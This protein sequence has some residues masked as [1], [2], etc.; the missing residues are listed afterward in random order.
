MNK[1]KLVTTSIPYV[2]DKFPEYY[3]ICRKIKIYLMR[4]KLD[5]EINSEQYLTLAG[6][7]RRINKNHQNYINIKN[8]FIKNNHVA[9]WNDVCKFS[10][11]YTRYIQG[12][13]LDFD[14]RSK[15]YLNWVFGL[16]CDVSGDM[17]MFLVPNSKACAEIYGEGPDAES[18]NNNE[19]E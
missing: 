14:Y 7:I 12:S 18:E 3:E 17:C 10:K 5:G 13:V 2:V 15:T 11:I 19:G 6:H 16:N 1:Y 8:W 9:D 4:Y